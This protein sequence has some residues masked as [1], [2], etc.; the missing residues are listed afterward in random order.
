MN[1]IDAKTMRRFSFWIGPECIYKGQVQIHSRPYKQKP[2]G[3]KCHLITGQR[4]K[5]NKPHAISI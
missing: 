2:C 3:W 1:Q 4:Q 5:E